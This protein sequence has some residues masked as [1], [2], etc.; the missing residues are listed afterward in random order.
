MNFVMHRNRTIAS[1]T[2]HSVEFVKG[3][4]THVPPCMHD[5]VMAAGAVPEYEI[6]EPEANP[7]AKIV[8]SDP[9][10]RQAAM[11]AAFDTLVLRKSRDDFTAGGS[12]HLKALALELGWPVDAKEREVA[13]VNYNNQKAK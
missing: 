6:E 9:G 3:Q 11:F 1:K 5:E 12:P 8:P 10:E 2:G 4:L 13:W 7:N